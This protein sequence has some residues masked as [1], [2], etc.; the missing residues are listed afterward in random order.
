[1]NR[2]YLMALVALTAACCEM[3]AELVLP[4]FMTDSMVVQQKSTLRV[5]GSG[6]GNIIVKPSWSKKDFC[7]KVE[8]DGTFSVLLPTPKAGGPYRIS[9]SDNDGNL[10]LND[11]YSGEVWLCAGQSNMEMPLGGWGK[12]NDYENEIASANWPMVRLLKVERQKAFAPQK[13]TEV[14]MG[15]WRTATP[16]TVEEFS[17]IGYF[18]GRDLSKA[19]GGIPVGI[20]DSSWGGTVAQ[21]WTSLGGV[22]K[23][24]GFD[25]ETD[26]LRMSDGSPELLRQLHQLKNYMWRE[27]IQ[28]ST[29]P[30]NPDVVNPQSNVTVSVPGYTESSVNKDFDGLYWLQ[31]AVDIPTSFVGRDI[32]LNLGM[33][34]DEDVAYFNG[35][36]IANG[37]GYNSPRRYIVPGKFVKP[38]KAVV[39]VRISDYL[40]NGGILGN[41]EDINIECGEEKIPLAGRWTYTE[42]L[43]F[44]A[45]GHQPIGHH[46]E[47]FPTVLYNAMIAPLNVLPVKGV[48]W[49][50]GCSDVGKAEQYSRMFKQLINDWRTY[51]NAP[52]MPFYFMQLASYLAPQKI[53]P[54]SEWAALR[55]AQADAMVLP[56]VYMASAIDIGDANDIHPKN[57][58]EAARRFLNLALAKSYGRKNIVCEAPLMS[59]CIFD[60]NRAI[61]R[62]DGRVTSDA[63]SIKGFIVRTSDGKWC[64]VEARFINSSEVELK[65][66][67]QIEEVKYNWADF[68]DGNLR[69]KTGLPVTPF[70]AIKK[71]VTNPVIE[72]WYADPEAVVYNN[73]Y[74]IFPTSSLPFDEQTYMDAYSSTDLRNWVKHPRILTSDNVKWGK[75]AFWAPA[76]IE[77]DGKYYL[78]FSANDVHEG[79]IGGIGVAVAD[80]PEGPYKDLIGKPLVNDIVMGAQP[81]DQFVFR[82]DD[83]RYYMYYGG[84]GHCLLVALADDFKSLVPLP[85]GS[86]Y[87]EVTPDNY[88]EGPFMFKRNGKYY[89][90]WSE[91]DWTKDNYFVSYAISD[92]PFGPFISKGR[93]LEADGKIGSGAGHH[94]VINVPAT[95]EYYIVYHMHPTDDKEGNHR[96][97]CI[98]EMNFDS[99]GNILPVKITKAGVKIRPLE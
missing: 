57:K 82:N 44:S 51:R 27:G 6:S 5:E 59:K 38:G 63:D 45:Y 52:D 15:G 64:S 29:I 25:A 9:I 10:T 56:N 21:A 75:R 99:K 78:F 93:I 42:Q 65:A 79:E 76:S 24:G 70:V 13:D 96:Q 34:D 43:D 54:D 36:A 67:Q 66:L 18:F 1:M 86:M 46:L 20:I 98:D 33:I 30:L 73:T 89:F 41:P 16:Q 61:I 26:M 17:S 49:Y 3:K 72:G 7:T 58:Q 31:Y 94:S 48:L 80:R 90:M 2:K 77:K 84:W 69:G 71:N 8:N 53:Q 74:W 95:D 11:I 35:V 23:V 83:G 32:I 91:G 19:L 88:T 60:G 39:S 4:H 14:K 28:F 47:S 62:F 92:S 87:K 12:V 37:E 97:I 85:N 81:I 40:G 22:E 55:Q 68:P 50:Q